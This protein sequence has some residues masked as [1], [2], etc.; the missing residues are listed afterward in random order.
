M[1]NMLFD[2]TENHLNYFYK[3]HTVN[4]IV[5]WFIT[6]LFSVLSDNDVNRASKPIALS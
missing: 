4:V 6:N 1:K 2:T 5:V 3:Y